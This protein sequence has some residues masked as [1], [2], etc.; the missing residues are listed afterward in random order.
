MSKTD[1]FK[2]TFQEWLELFM[3]RSM[4]RFIHYARKSGLSMSMIGALFHL[5]NRES[6]GVTD[7]GEH[8]GVTSAASSQ[9]LERLVQQGLIQRTEDPDDRRVK[10]IVLTKKGCQVLEEGTHARQGWLDE[11]S[12]NLSAEEKEQIATAL[13]IMINKANQLE[14]PLQK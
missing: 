11:L 3:H 12:E 7:L 1:P 10:Q 9:M 14:E 4:R 2:S 13:D 8:L 5:H 6:A